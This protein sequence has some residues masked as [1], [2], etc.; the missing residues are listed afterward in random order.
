MRRVAYLA[1][2]VAVAVSSCSATLRMSAVA[3][4]Q[5]NDGTCVAPVLYP[6]PAGAMRVVHF[7]WTGPASGQDSVV[8]LA[9][10]LATLTATVPPGTYNI[11]GWV[12]GPGG[13]G[14]DS[15]ITRTASSPPWKPAFQ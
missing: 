13:V 3:P 14:C 5:D 15:T 7:Q 2:L 11:R 8:V 6:S 1:A 9:G 12:S 4:A 10:S